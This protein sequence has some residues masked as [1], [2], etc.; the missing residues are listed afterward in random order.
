[1]KQNNQ[2]TI[3]KILH[4][5]LEFELQGVI[6]YTYYY[7]ILDKANREAKI[8]NFLKEQAQESLHHAQLVSDVLAG[9]NEYEPLAIL[10]NYHL[11]NY[12]AIDILLASHAHEQQAVE[13]YKHLLEVVKG[14]NKYLEEFTSKMV[15]EEEEHTQE[16]QQ[17]INEYQV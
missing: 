13:Y 10:P 12:N 9:L 6:R 16:L 1:M 5:I 8:L 3:T 7:V 14:C 4:K 15:I 17:M 2:E 11:N